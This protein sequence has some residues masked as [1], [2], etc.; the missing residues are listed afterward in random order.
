LVVFRMV[1]HGCKIALIFHCFGYQKSHMDSYY[2]P[3]LTLAT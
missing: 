2:S 1:Y 3:T